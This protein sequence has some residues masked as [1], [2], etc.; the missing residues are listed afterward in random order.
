MCAA[1]A[2]IISQ[3]SALAGS[4]LTFL[5]LG[6]SVKAFRVTA[7]PCGNPKLSAHALEMSTC[8]PSQAVPPQA[9]CH[10]WPDPVRPALTWQLTAAR[11]SRTNAHG[12]LAV[13]SSV[14]LL[15]VASSSISIASTLAVL[16]SNILSWLM[17]PEPDDHSSFSI[18]PTASTVWL[19]KL[20]LYEHQAT[21]E[22]H[23]SNSS[24]KDGSH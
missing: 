8:C 11:T 1:W 6:T 14:T 20:A 24:A 17:Q 16:L 2:L 13:T 9:T 18:C 22:E 3:S 23:S 10:T 4:T 5:A 21:P 15:R 19:L 12:K 7:S